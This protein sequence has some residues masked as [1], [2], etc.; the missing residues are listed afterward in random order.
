MGL[1][2]VYP[3]NQMQMLQALM[4]EQHLFTAIIIHKN[5]N[6]NI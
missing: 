4:L 3:P 1:E 5:I 2:K 6:Q